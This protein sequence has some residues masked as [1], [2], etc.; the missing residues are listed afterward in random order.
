MFKNLIKTGNRPLSNLGCVYVAANDATVVGIVDDFLI[1]PL[2][3]GVSGGLTL[4]LGGV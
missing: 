4:M 2:G 1:A 3:A